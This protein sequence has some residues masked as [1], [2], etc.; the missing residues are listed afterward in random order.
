MARKA[1]LTL[2][3][4]LL[5]F[6]LGCVRPK[7][8]LKREKPKQK[9]Q[10]V[11]QK[12]EAWQDFF[13]YFAH[14]DPEQV[15]PAQAYPIYR[16]KP[17]G[18]EMA[19]AKFGTQIIYSEKGCSFSSDGKRVAWTE[20]IGSNQVSVVNSD[21][22]GKVIIKEGIESYQP[23][24]SHEGATVALV[25]VQ[26]FATERM[27]ENIALAHLGT[28]TSIIQTQ[29]PYQGSSA[30][31]PC[32]DLFSRRIYFDA[33]IYESRDIF[34][35]DAETGKGLIRLTADRY[36]NSQPCVTPDGKKV[37][38]VSSRGGKLDIYAVPNKGIP[39]PDEVEDWREQETK[40]RENDF[41]KNQQVF[42]LTQEG[43]NKNP[44]IS[45]DGKII[46]FSSNR[47]GNWEIYLMRVDGTAQRRFT[48]NNVDDLAPSWSPL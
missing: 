2:L 5:L 23:V 27:R 10:V 13:I 47:D 15:A 7:T 48:F 19:A 42:R 36:D 41:F 26:E 8:V 4:F 14:R 34:S 46:A 40:D 35:F 38:F 9:K 1:F 43:E 25:V 33:Q 39:V 16:M 37:V 31:S 44:A 3:L 17:D 6:S 29:N 32:Y 30:S 28:T 12:R 45:P 20:L 18:S 22:S 11:E 21:G 24:L